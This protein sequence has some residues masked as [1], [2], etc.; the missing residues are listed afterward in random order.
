VCACVCVRVCVCACVR[1]CVCA[2]VRVRMCALVCVHRKADLN[3]RIG[4]EVVG[5]EHPRTEVSVLKYCSVLQCAAVCF[6]VLQ[7]VTSKN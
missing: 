4:R 6:S 1:V 3:G 5:K 7:C 2:C